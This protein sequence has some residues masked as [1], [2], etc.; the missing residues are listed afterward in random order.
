VIARRAAALLAAIVMIAAAIA[1]R[2]LVLNDDDDAGAS[3]SNK[4]MRLTCVTELAAPCE[5]I[6]RNSDGDVKVTVE[7]AGA[8]AKRLVEATDA[9]TLGIDGWLTIAP[10]PEI[11]AQRRVRTNVDPILGPT[12]SRLARSPL[13]LAA[14]KDRLAALDGAC[15]AGVNWKCL[16]NYADTPFADINGDERWATVKPAHAEPLQSATGLLV[17]GQA[18]AQFLAPK[19][20]IDQISNSNFDD[21]FARWF[22]QLETSIPPDAIG[23][24]ADPVARWVVR[25]GINYAA[26]G[27]LEAQIGPALN[28][29]RALKDNATVIYPAPMASADVVFSPI[30]GKGNDGVKS[31]SSPYAHAAFARAGWRVDG[32]PR[33][34]GVGSNALPPK[35]GLPSAGLL[36]YL[37]TYWSGVVR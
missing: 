22:Q 15:A 34:P 17:L 7:A 29:A 27:G 30:V 12:S 4:T 21:K 32:Q 10:W 24:G 35:N 26:V 25:R 3:G 19:V 33:L 8:T 37:Q 2:S 1:V 14:R 16:G 9:A 13:V 31:V 36:D 11:V 23:E 5:E 20:P 18:V 6:A 28:G